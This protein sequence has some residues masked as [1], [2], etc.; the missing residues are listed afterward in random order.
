M[1]Y[2]K[3]E[4]VLPQKKVIVFSDIELFCYYKYI[5]LQNGYFDVSINEESIR[6]M[7]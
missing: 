1:C 2:V 7:P 3:A 6:Y 4:D 5:I